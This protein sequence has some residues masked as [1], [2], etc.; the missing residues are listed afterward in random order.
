MHTL[1]PN[2]GSAGQHNRQAWNRLAEQQQRFTRA[3]RD[4]EFVDPLGLLDS[5]GWLA[6]GIRGKNLLCLAAG[7]GRQGPLYAAAGANVTVVDISNAQL[8]LDRA[9]AAERRLA[10]R[11]VE[12]S[13]DDLGMFRAGEFEVVI[14]PVSSCYLP[15][16]RPV[17]EQVA[18]VTAADGIYISQHKQPT[19]LQSDPASAGDGYRVRE[20]YYRQGPLPAVQGS[21]H[22]EEGT[23]EFLHR[24]EELL[25]AMC[26]VGFSI[27]DLTEPC[28]ARPQAE[29]G[30][31]AHRSQFIPPYV[32]VKARRRGSP[33][34]ALQLD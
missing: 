19:S 15:D 13:M 16:L 18:R 33:R 10:I 21:L 4:E 31:F 26:R 5:S 7:G 32:R 20:P 1:P 34:I 23:L 25:G 2:N 12:T 28:H 8:Q 24:W 29:P 9:V 22:R 11:T 27:E 14:H 3:A 30:S 17:Y 6:E